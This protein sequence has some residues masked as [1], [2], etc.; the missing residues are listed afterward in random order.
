MRIL[1]LLW[2][3]SLGG[4]GKCALAYSRLNEIPDIEIDTVCIYGINWKSDLEPLKAIGATLVPIQGRLDISWISRCS[5]L[6]KS[7]NPDIVFVHGFNGP[8]VVWLCQKKLKYKFPFVCS[9]HGKYYAPRWSRVPLEPV[10]NR[11]MELIYRR[12]AIG[13]VAVARH[14]KECL[15]RKGI[16]PEKINV[17]H[18]GLPE[19]IKSNYSLSKSN[20]GLEDDNLII[21]V[22]SRIDPKKGLDYLVEGFSYI[23][24][25]YPQA[26]LVIVGDGPYMNKLRNKATR[27]GVDQKIILAGFQADVDEWLDIFDIFVL[28]T[29]SEAHSISLLEGMR[30]GKPI[31]AT[32][33]GGNPESIEHEKQGLLVPPADA[34]AL[35]KAILRM[36][37]NPELRMRLGASARKRFEVEFTEDRMLEKIAAW[38]MG[39]RTREERVCSALPAADLTEE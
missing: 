10:F 4:I 31:V 29:L 37:E 36:I 6:V 23:A 27:L 39:F 34:A 20:L 13:I 12:Y 30:A 8:V 21:G 24:K 3:F 26:I 5:I 11:V 22:V 7:Y 25:Y 2:G 16:S 19:R 9:Y 18:N 14:C 1:S 38:L 28:P 17:V 15:V 32:N 35:E 33:V